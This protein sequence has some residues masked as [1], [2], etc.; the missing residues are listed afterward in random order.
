[1]PSMRKS[2]VSF[3]IKTSPRSPAAGDYTPRGRTIRLR[4]RVLFALSHDLAGI[5]IDA[6][7]REGVADEE[8]VRLVGIEALAIL[9]VGI[10]DDRQRQLYR[11]RH[12]LALERIERRLDRHGHLRRAG[13]RRSA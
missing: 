13:A 9:E 4:S 2:G 10:G 7:C 12:D 6:A 8:I 1:M 3:G 5:E 11:L